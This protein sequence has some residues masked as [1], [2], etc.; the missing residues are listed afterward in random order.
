MVL[1]AASMQ[2]HGTS[3]DPSLGGFRFPALRLRNSRHQDF[4]LIWFLAEIA[5]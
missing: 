1:P 4:A 2:R 3:T 5:L